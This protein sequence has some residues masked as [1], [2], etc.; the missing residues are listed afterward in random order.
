[1]VCHL[2]TDLT[3]VSHFPGRTMIELDGESWNAVSDGFDRL[4]DGLLIREGSRAIIG[5]HWAS[6][7]ENLGR[8]DPRK[9]KR[10]LSSSRAPSHLLCTVLASHELSS[11][12][13]RDL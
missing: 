7:D 9:M 5:P 4:S 2:M 1:M 6:E 8:F 11:Q 10:E 13:S 3:F 12:G